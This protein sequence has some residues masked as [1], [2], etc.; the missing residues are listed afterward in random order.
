MKKIVFII[1]CLFSFYSAKSQTLISAKEASQNVGKTV[2]I[3]D[4]IFGAKSFDKIS[5]LNIG[6]IYPNEYLTIVINKI[7]ENKFPKPPSEMYLN[8][9][10]C[11]TGLITEFKGKVQIVVTDPKQIS[12]K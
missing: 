1:F 11:F 8:K 10:I 9:K 7:D 3:C 5:L 2:L 12:I 6:A 4:S